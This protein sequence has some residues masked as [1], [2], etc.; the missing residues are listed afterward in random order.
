LKCRQHRHGYRFSIDAV[1]LAHFIAP[2]NN[3][4]LLDLG[5]GCGI[6]SLLLAYRW[7]QL[8]VTALELQPRLAALCRHN[9][10]VNGFAERIAAVEG[11]F[12]RMG[13]FFRAGSFSWVVANPPYRPSN[14]GRLS[15]GEEQAVARHELSGG[16]DELVKAIAFALKTR[17][18][19][20]LVYPAARSA[21][22]LAALK[23]ARLEPKRLQV[24]YSYPGSAGRLM[25]VEAVKG[26][27]EG[28]SILPPFYIYD[29]PGGQYAPEMARCYAPLIP[30]VG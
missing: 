12:R 17:G 20:A 21:I 18:R 15:G 8:A 22:L 28:M 16:L 14:H 2:G 19:A 6:V 5:A 30:V 26:G 9:A 24:V 3:G 27:G 1:L 13:D 25:L 4:I 7:P 10:A 29:S 23:A 11:D